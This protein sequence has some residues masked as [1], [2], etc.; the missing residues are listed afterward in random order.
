MNTIGSYDA[1]THLARLLDEAAQGRSVTITRHGREVA[2]L[3]P[4]P[5]QTAPTD[6]IIAALRGGRQGVRRGRSSV[7]KMIAEG[8]R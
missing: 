5:G 8:R 7:R 3:V 6:E 1:K 2:R 4:A